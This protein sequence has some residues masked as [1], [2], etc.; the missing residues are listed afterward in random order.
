[1]SN[2]KDLDIVVGT[3]SA[4]ISDSEILRNADRLFEDKQI[5]ADRANMMARNATR[6]VRGVNFSGNSGDDTFYVFGEISGAHILSGGRG[7]DTL[8]LR[9]S[10][11]ARD[12]KVTT[13][14]GNRYRIE[15]GNSTIETNG[16]ERIGY[17]GEG[18]MSDVRLTDLGTL[19]R[20]PLHQ[21]IENSHAEFRN[22]R[23]HN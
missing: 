10:D 7:N 2:D 5:S 22:R 18:N 12:A 16:I 23:G 6:T 4:R 17:F 14:G 20:V 15:Y 1:M 19:N 13:L 21:A 8:V 3:R 9:S 11:Q